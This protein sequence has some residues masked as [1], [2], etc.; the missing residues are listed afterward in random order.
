MRKQSKF[1]FLVLREITGTV[2]VFIDQP[3]LLKIAETLPS[4]SVVQ[5][6]GTVKVEKQAPNGFEILASTIEV[7]SSPVEELPF[8]VY[9]KGKEP[10]LPLRLDYRW[11]DLRKPEKALIFKI[12]TSMGK[13]MREFWEQEGFIEIK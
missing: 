7:L 4:E 8:Q 2:Q 12:W 10:E 11:I 9:E 6:E 5:I 1:A 13:Y 3:Q